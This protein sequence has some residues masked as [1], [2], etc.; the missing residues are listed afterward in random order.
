MSH[1]HSFFVFN[2]KKEFELYTEDPTLL[3]VS[4]QPLYVMVEYAWV[5]CKCGLVKR[6]KVKEEKIY[7]D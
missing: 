2:T 3:E 5:N 6:T 4:G 7:D 1:E